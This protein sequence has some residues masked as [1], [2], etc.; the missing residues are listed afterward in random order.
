[1]VS[2]IDVDS[3]ELI[4]EAA[5]QLK[6]KLEMP[7]WAHFTKTGTHKQRPPESA[8]WWYMRAASLMRKIYINGPVGVE[9]LKSVYGGRKNRGHKPSHFKKAGGKVIRV[10]LQDLE[11]LGYVKKVIKP[12]RGRIITP[13]G[14]KFMDNAAK[15]VSL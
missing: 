4:K 1:M 3:Q 5:E 7:E 12:S 13:A 10:L 14:Q 8:D 2:V 6:G 11:K 9:K 15:K